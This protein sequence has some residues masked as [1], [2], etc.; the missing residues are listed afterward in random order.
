[1]KPTF[2]NNSKIPLLIRLYYREEWIRDSIIVAILLLI[3]VAIAIT[4]ETS[5]E[6][7]E[8]FNSLNP[9][10]NFSILLL[11]FSNMGVLGAAQKKHLLLPCSHI[12]RVGFYFWS[13]MIRPIIFGLFIYYV[14]AKIMWSIHYPDSQA[15]RVTESSEVILNLV[16][17]TLFSLSFI[18]TVILTFYKYR[19]II[20]FF[21][22]FLSLPIIAYLL[23]PFMSKEELSLLLTDY[24]HTYAYLINISL[25]VGSVLCWTANYFIIKNKKNL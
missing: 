12:D 8:S 6:T 24:A 7:I 17:T 10:M 4:G 1:M 14:V 11:L 3:L 15:I 22:Y 18:S 25:A 19:I 5:D 20:L 9:A 16:L 13:T 21:L 2:L 23:S